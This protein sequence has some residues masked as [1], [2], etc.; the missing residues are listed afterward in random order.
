MTLSELSSYIYLFGNDV[1]LLHLHTVGTHFF[2][3]H[4]KLNELYDILFNF[5]DAL[6][7]SAITHDEEIGNPSELILDENISWEVLEGKDFDVEEIIS[8]V[9]EKG[10]TIM[11]YIEETNGYESWVQSKIDSFAE[12]LD[13]CINYMFK[14]SAK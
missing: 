3:Y 11:N 4:E 8:I 1:R 2:E 13:T 12:N 9:L 6:A 5:Y 10:K 14:Q 7:E